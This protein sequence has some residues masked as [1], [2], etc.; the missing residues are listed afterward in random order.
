[1]T[2]ATTRAEAV[3]DG[4]ACWLVKVSTVRSCAWAQG[5]TAKA[6]TLDILDRFEA[7]VLLAK[8]YDRLDC[9]EDPEQLF[10]AA[11]AEEV[12]K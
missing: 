2:R 5:P 11:L 6:I 8:K 12:G 3:N 1:M 4:L 7:F 10:I 9:I